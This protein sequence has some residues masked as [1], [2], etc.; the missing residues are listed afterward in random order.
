[1]KAHTDPKE[2]NYTDSQGDYWR[3]YRF[4]RD[5]ADCCGTM[6]R[7]SPSKRAYYAELESDIFGEIELG[8][9]RHIADW[10]AFYYSDEFGTVVCHRNRDAGSYMRLA[11]YVR[12]FTQETNFQIHPMP[13]KSG[14]LR[15]N[16]LKEVRSFK[17]HYAIPPAP[18]SLDL[19]DGDDVSKEV[20]EDI[21]RIG[22]LYD[23]TEITIIISQGKSRRR[24]IPN[25]AKQLLG[26]AK[27]MF[28][29]GVRTA[30]ASGIND[31]LEAEPYIDLMEHTLVSKVEIKYIA[32]SESIAA[33]YDALKIG[34]GRL[35]PQIEAMFKPL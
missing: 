34:Y 26:A 30:G 18:V 17:L 22:R 5:G 11:A 3:L 14:L 20:L 1:L 8:E 10:F 25:K 33:C 9:K 13:D 6:L 28:G 7:I 32:G 12:N 27:N 29:N 16:R 15:M 19:F 35:R 23:G 21:T 4:T 2:L 24:L 31:N